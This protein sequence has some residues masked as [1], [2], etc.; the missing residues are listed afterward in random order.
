MNIENLVSFFFI[1]MYYKYLYFFMGFF[2]NFEI[3]LT[4]NITKTNNE[5]RSSA[6]YYILFKEGRDWVLAELS[7]I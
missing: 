7:N 1:Y 4:V 6:L 5:K 3:F 2:L